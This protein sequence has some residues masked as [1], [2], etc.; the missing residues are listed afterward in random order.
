MSGM[1]LTIASCYTAAFATAAIVLQVISQNWV[2]RQTLLSWILWLKRHIRELSCSVYH[3]FST[4]LLRWIMNRFQRSLYF[5][6]RVY[7]LL[8]WT[9][10]A[11]TGKFKITRLHLRSEVGDVIMRLL[12]TSTCDR[13]VVLM[14]T[15]FYMYTQI[16]QR[17]F[18]ILEISSNCPVCAS[19]VHDST[20][21]WWKPNGVTLVFDKLHLNLK[22]IDAG[23]YL[24]LSLL[25]LVYFFISWRFV[26]LCWSLLN[27]LNNFTILYIYIYTYFVCV[28]AV[29]EWMLVMKLGQSWDYTNDDVHDGFAMLISALLFVQRRCRTTLPVRILIFFNTS[30]PFFFIFFWTRLFL[31]L[32]MPVALNETHSK[33]S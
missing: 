23:M 15:A 14:E 32:Y 22:C 27:V 30:I 16:Y 5:C 2:K 17:N 3:R 1:C 7:Y 8:T 26:T 18:G 6:L 9:N 19:F 10:E 29:L 11:L 13:T 4:L 20:A 28:C 33:G 25:L 21:S 24:L 31:R 12:R